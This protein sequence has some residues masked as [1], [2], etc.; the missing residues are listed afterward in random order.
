MEQTVDRFKNI[1]KLL[2]LVDLEVLS[3]PHKARKS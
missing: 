3:A 2:N 1:I